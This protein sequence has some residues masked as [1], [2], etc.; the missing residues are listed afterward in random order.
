MT[1]IYHWKHE[2]FLITR[3]LENISILA[4]YTENMYVKMQILWHAQI[5][6]V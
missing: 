2:R 5:V 4:I 3:I 1:R 6:H